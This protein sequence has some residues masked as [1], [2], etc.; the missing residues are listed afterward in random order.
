V[1]TDGSAWGGGYSNYTPGRGNFGF[2]VQT[3]GKTGST[4]TSVKGQL[5]WV[6]KNGWKFKGALASYSLNSGTGTAK[7]TGSL[8]YWKKSASGG[9][10]V[11]ATTGS[12]T[13]TISFTATT[14]STKYKAGTPGSFGISFGGIK[15]TGVT[16][17]PSYPI[18]T[19]AYGNIK[20][21]L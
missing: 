6:Q 3:F 2:E 19:I 5:A 10:W 14:A 21:N 16:S 9:N 11:A 7:G 20:M 13:V 15:A 8:F 18:S 12:A 4:P 17:L 1:S